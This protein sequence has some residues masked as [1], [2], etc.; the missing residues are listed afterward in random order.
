[1][2]RKL[3]WGRR[4]LHLRPLA[5]QACRARAPSS[6][7]A[8]ALVGSALAGLCLL[9]D[10]PQYF[11]DRRE[12]LVGENDVETLVR[13]GSSLITSSNAS[14]LSS[15]RSHKSRTVEQMVV[16][17]VDVTH[18]INIVERILAQR[19]EVSRELACLL[20]SPTA[21]AGVLSARRGCD[22]LCADF[23]AARALTA[24]IAPGTKGVDQG[25]RCECE[26]RLCKCECEHVADPI[27]S[28]ISSGAWNFFSVPCRSQLYF[29]S[30]CL[31]VLCSGLPTRGGFPPL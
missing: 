5:V 26:T 28:V 7:N 2:P 11:R 27:V 18:S 23:R 12:L 14:V 1:M 3:G 31:L 6:L 24:C 20:R 30:C 19:A 29:R 16:P 4:R 15:P 9:F 13:Q 25:V 17:D 10:F 22:T 21:A 8:H